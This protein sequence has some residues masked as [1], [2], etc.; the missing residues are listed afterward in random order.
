M[1]KIRNLL[2]SSMIALASI[3]I[4]ASAAD[5]KRLPQEK[6]EDWYYRCELV[7]VPNQEEKKICWLGQD[8]VLEDTKNKGKEKKQ[9]LP[10][11]AL[12]IHKTTQKDKKMTVFAVRAPLGVDLLAGARLRIDD[13]DYDRK[14]YIACF[15][16]P[17]GCRSS[18]IVE[19]ELENALK[20][21][22]KIEVAYIMATDSKVYPINISTKGYNKAI[23]KLSF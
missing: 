7:K 19:K 2:I 14:P 11:L 18:F 15:P 16:Q 3:T 5:V 10:L 21:G 12:E 4:N 1:K 22:K 23:N 6:I 17:L 9:P 8:F 13:K 20:N